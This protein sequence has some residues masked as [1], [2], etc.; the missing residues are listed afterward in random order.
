LSDD[1]DQRSD[2][3][4]LEEEVRSRR[5]IAMTRGHGTRAGDTIAL[6]RS[7]IRRGTPATGP[8]LPSQPTSSFHASPAS[9]RIVG[10]GGIAR[11]PQCE[12]YWPVS[13]APRF[14]HVLAHELSGS[15]SIAVV[16]QRLSSPRRIT[17]QSDCHERRCE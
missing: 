5:S 2:V 3:L 14:W 4:R 6:R 8:R 15:E 10:R 16:H 7:L 12:Q 9:S 13:A 17:A 11:C 1:G